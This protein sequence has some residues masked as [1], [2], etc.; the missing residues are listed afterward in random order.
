VVSYFIDT[1]GHQNHWSL[2]LL[3]GRTPESV[4]VAVTTE[5]VPAAGIPD[6]GVNIR[7]AVV[8]PVAGNVKRQ[9]TACS[10]NVHANQ[11]GPLAGLH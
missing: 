2:D 3:L 9:P 1:V 11:E 8:G 6:D 10:I 4:H 5:Q 7:I